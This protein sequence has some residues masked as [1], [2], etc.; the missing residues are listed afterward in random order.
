MS[1]AEIAIEHVLWCAEDGLM[2]RG[3]L[4]S[5]GVTWPNDREPDWHDVELALALAY[6]QIQ[7]RQQYEDQRLKC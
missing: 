5:I 4:A 3:V 2:P 1:A 6:R 7:P